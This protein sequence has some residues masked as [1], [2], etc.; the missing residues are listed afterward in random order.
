MVEGPVIFRSQ[1]G[2]TTIDKFLTAELLKDFCFQ[3]FQGLLFILIAREKRK[4]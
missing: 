4:S 2:I 1:S 3:G